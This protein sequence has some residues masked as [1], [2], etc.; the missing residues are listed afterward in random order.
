MERSGRTARSPATRVAPS[1]TS[2]LPSTGREAAIYTGPSPSACWKAVH[3]AEK[4]ADAATSPEPMAKGAGFNSLV[5]VVKDKFL[6]AEELARLVRKLPPETAEAVQSPPLPMAWIPC[7]RYGDLLSGLLEHAFRGDEERIVELGRL[8]FLYDLKTLYRVFIKLMSPGFVIDRASRL[9]Q[10]YNK[11]NGALSA[12][13]V[14]ETRCEV[15]YERIRARYPGFWAHQRGCLIAGV[16]ATGFPRATAVV[17]RPDD[18]QGN[19][20]VTVDWA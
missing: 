19:A 17:T 7:A 1:S 3:P 11:D 8:A 16:Q 12:R 9:F 20:L 4:S 6:S 13:K 14:G 2:A 5:A 18:G 10:T 15:T